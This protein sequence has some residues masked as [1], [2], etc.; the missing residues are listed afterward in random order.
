MS[1]ISFQC[2][3]RFPPPFNSPWIREAKKD[4]QIC[5]IIN[6]VGSLSPGARVTTQ[7]VRVCLV[8][9]VM[10]HAEAGLG[11]VAAVTPR[12]HRQHGRLR[13]LMLREGGRGKLEPWNFQASWADAQPRDWTKNYSSQIK[14]KQP[15]SDGATHSFEIVIQKIAPLC[16]LDRPQPWL[17]Q[18]TE[19]FFK[20]VILKCRVVPRQKSLRYGQLYFDQLNVNIA[21]YRFAWLSPGCNLCFLMS[22]HLILIYYKIL[23]LIFTSYN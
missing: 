11:L 16:S 10:R 3:K 18:D 13:V 7:E 1:S 22:Q 12:Q 9:L 19:L 23:Q 20:S 17:A 5:S 14:G 6:L 4:F 2:Q 21:N 15:R 8:T